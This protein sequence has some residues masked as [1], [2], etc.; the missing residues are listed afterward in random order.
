MQKEYDVKEIF[1]EIENELILSMKRTLWSHKKDEKTKGFKWPQWQALKLKQLEDFKKN[2]QKIFDDHKNTIIDNLVHK[3]I[4]KQFKE[5]ASRTNKEA[6]KAG[7]IKKSDS[8]L[9]GSFFRT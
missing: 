9:G 3:E 4:K 1:E 7:K 6:I 8:Q 2:N 5:G